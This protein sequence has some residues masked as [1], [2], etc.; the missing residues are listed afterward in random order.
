MRWVAALLLLVVGM[1]GQ[2]KKQVEETEEA[3]M[4][5][6]PEKP[7]RPAQCKRYVRRTLAEYLPVM[8]RGLVE[9]ASK[10]SCQ[11]IKLATEL[12]WA[13]ET[14][15]ERREKSS[16]TRMLEELNRM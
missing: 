6:L 13:Q 7:L 10:G 8:L 1:T 16:V 2:A 5:E 4:F 9:G 14:A 15:P 3:F 12:L 11:H